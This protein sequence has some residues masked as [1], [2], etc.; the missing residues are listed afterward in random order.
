[1]AH[2]PLTPIPL[3]WRIA[4]LLAVALA[5]LV[6]DFGRRSVTGYRELSAAVDRI[7]AARATLE[8]IV[9]FDASR[10]PA[11][12]AIAVAHADLEEANRRFERADRRLSYVPGVARLF[13][14]VPRWGDSLGHAQDALRAGR[15]VAGSTDRLVR[16]LDA[17]VAGEGRIA[18]RAYQTFVIDAAP[19]LAELE[20]LAA[21]RGDLERLAAVDWHPPFGRV[22][23][24][25][26]L[27]LAE[28]ERVEEARDIATGLRDGL[29]VL[30]GY[31][32]PRTLLLL[33]QN[34]HEVRPTGGF[35]GTVGLLT[36]DQGRVTSR[37]F[38]SS[39]DFDA[40]TRD[41][42]RTPPLDLSSSLGIGEWH[43]RD[44][45]WSPDFRVSG[46]TARRFL[47]EDLG[48]EADSVVAVDSHFVALLLGALGP[49]EVDGYDEPLTQDSWFVQAENSIYALE[50]GETAAPADV[51]EGGVNLVA[52]PGFEASLAGWDAAGDAE[53]DLLEALEDAAY[54][55]GALRVDAHSAG[56]GA[57]YTGAANARAGQAY[58]ASVSVRAADAASVGAEVQLLFEARGGEYEQASTTIR[59][60][61]QWQRFSVTTTWAN[62]GH[63]GWGL[64]VR[65][66]IGQSLVVE[67]DGVQVEAGPEATPYE[68]TDRTSTEQAGGRGVARQAY[69]SPVLDTLLERAELASGDTVPALIGAL[70]Q[71]VRARN[72]QLYSPHGSVAALARQLEVDGAIEAPADGDQLVVVDANVSYSKLQPAITRSITYLLGQDGHVDILIRWRNDLP[73]FD[74]GRYARLG[75]D[76]MI[77]D[78][79]A[80][81]MNTAPGTFATYTRLILRGDAETVRTTGFEQRG[82]F[83]GEDAL[84]FA[85]RVIVPPGEEAFVAVSYE[86]PDRPQT[87]RLWKQGGFASTT[88]KVLVNQGGTQHVAFEGLLLEDT[89]V[90]LKAP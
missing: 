57:R 19:L 22:G 74:G 31:D 34:D 10:W 13:A 32:Q 90:D 7:E 54:G 2:S 48:V 38:G 35:I 89:V 20:T 41:G 26:Q 44:A 66:A 50:F 63:T 80:Y 70:S 67:M 14:W 84:T 79:V 75:Q 58:T 25:L 9:R 73:T 88:V 86:L 28:L 21:L 69:L 51:G 47:A 78:P 83:P 49:V 72:L 45:N 60:S 30:L 64:T 68:E 5:V 29:P 3:R 17:L 15:T 76:G 40:P 24:A 6:F 39:Y 46:E 53:L 37:R 43:I 18:D 81:R 23:R 62:E 1:M 16:R 56:G 4:T 55:S 85:G 8:P 71:A 87:L 59:L 61:D 77:W 33:G 36:L 11:A 27:A 65:D 52:N 12:E 82:L 42:L